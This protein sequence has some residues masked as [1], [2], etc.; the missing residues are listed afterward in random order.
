MAELLQFLHLP[1]HG[2]LIR[3]LVLR[4]SNDVL[5]VPRRFDPKRKD[6]KYKRVAGLAAALRQSGGNNCSR[7]VPQPTWKCASPAVILL[8]D[9][10][11]SWMV[12]HH[13]HVAEHGTGASW[14]DQKSTAIQ[15]FRGSIRVPNMMFQ[16]VFRQVFGSRSK[17]L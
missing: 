8:P 6:L 1:P 17:R 13:P 14:F 11:T 16:L 10:T 2:L 12:L 3:H 7:L 15:D 9:V 4:S 5:S